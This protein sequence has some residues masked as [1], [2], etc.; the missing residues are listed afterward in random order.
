M[1]LLLC[2]AKSSFCQIYFRPFSHRC[3]CLHKDAGQLL[4]PSLDAEFCE[5]AHWS[6][7]LFMLAFRNQT[8]NYC[9]HI[10]FWFIFGEKHN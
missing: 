6:V 8:E 1:N 3:L 9:C 7:H 2:L 4:S 10:L 5:S